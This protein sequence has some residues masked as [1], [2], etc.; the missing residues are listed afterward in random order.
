L[1]FGDDLLD[2]KFAAEVC[3][4]I[5]KYPQAA[6]IKTD[7]KIID[8]SAQITSVHKQLSVRQVTYPSR[9]W[10]EQFLGSKVSFFCFCCAS[11][12]LEAGKRFS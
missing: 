11:L 1:F 12:T 4:A 2:T 7:W 10:Q 8:K 3:T 5:E 6:L 9:T